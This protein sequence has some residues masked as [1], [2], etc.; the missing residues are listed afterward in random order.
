MCHE[1]RTPL[2]A[3]MGMT[4]IAQI[5]DDHDR[6]MNCLEKIDESSRHLLDIVDN[7]LD[8]A[9]IDTG[10]FELVPLKF[11][12]PKMIKRIIADISAKAGEKKQNFTFKIGSAIPDMI[13]ADERRLG[14]VLFQLLSN[15]VKFTPEHGFIYFSAERL[16]NTENACFLRFDVKDS[17]IGISPEM[18]ERLG[19]AF[20]Q[21]DN[22]ISRIHGGTGL[23]FAISKRIVEM[24]N[25]SI[26]VETELG[27]GSR[28]I[29][30]VQV[31]LDSIASQTETVNDSS[32]NSSLAGRHILVVDDVEINRDIIIAFLEDT[33][34]L[35]E[36]A[37]DGKL[38]VEMASRKQYDMILMDL[39][40]PGIDGFE[41]TRLIRAS[42]LPGRNSLPILAVTADSGG[43]V[44]SR[45]HK[46]GMNG[47][48][49]KPVD[50]GILIRTIAENLSKPQ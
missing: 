19:A 45:C 15:A 50:G 17:G 5:A 8:M 26:E 47:L 42:G 28:F 7:I 9:K 48:I 43:D 35:V 33:G 38:A 20:E 16:D 23:G 18:K 2:Y 32:Q 12:F 6:R 22:S 14:Q 41:A 3:I 4:T 36:D 10:N 46:A 24:M 39:H 40:M 21:M 34:A 25:G 13:I 1:M 29:C 31:G 11:C 49:G 27:K 30:T 37:S 44:L